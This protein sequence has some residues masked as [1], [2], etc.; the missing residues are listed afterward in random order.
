MAAATAGALPGATG[1]ITPSGTAAAAA[2]SG[3]GA[4]KR[5]PEWLREEMLKRQMA[6]AAAGGRFCIWV[7]WDEHLSGPH[8]GPSYLL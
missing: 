1:P 5:I 2:A 6:A 8:L 3:G 7:H 4:P